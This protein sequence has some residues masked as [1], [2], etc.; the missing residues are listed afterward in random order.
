MT[1]FLRV[2]EP[3]K[4]A[5]LNP[6]SGLHE[7]PDPRAQYTTEHPLVKAA[8]WAFGTDEEIASEADAARNVR[9]VPQPV[10]PVE[11]A[12]ANPGEKRAVR[13]GAGA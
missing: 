9:E 7:V 4:H 10:A 5:I 2:R 3:G 1:T 8:P 13:R 6:E 12:T 11:A